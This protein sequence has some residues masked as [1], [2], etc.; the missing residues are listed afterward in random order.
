MEYLTPKSKELNNVSINDAGSIFKIKNTIYRDYPI[1]T[2]GILCKLNNV[3]ILK[4]FNEYDIYFDSK[5]NI[6]LINAENYLSSKIY[7]Y[8]HLIKYKVMQG[9]LTVPRDTITDGYHENKSKT[10]YINIKY[11][12]KSAFLNIPIISIL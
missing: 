3:M 1:I 9:Y 4:K 11:V 10:F 5:E 12:K 7:N 2:F 6:D 8:K